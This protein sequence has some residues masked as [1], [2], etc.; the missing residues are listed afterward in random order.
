MNKLFSIV[1]TISVFVII[2]TTVIFAQSQTTI[3]TLEKSIVR[4]ENVNI[5]SGDCLS[6][7]AQEYN[8]SNM[9]DKDFTKYLKTFNNLKTDTIYYGDSILVPI[10]E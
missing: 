2:S 4:Y 5:E 3:P 8:T 10:F 9:S 7:I 6:L 1:F